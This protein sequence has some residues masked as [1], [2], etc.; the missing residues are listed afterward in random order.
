[1][2]LLHKMRLTFLWILFI[3]GVMDSDLELWVGEITVADFRTP[4]PHPPG[5]YHILVFNAHISFKPQ[6]FP[7]YCCH[8]L[9]VRK[10]SSEQFIVL[11]QATY[12]VVIFFAVI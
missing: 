11:P 10:L 3:I 12:L 4:P 8:I 9:Q 1:M 6:N 2:K 5:F 7:K